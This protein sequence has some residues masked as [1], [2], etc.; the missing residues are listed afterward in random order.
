M[1][2]NKLTITINRPI[3]EV[4]DFSLDPAN[5]PKWISDIEVEETSEWPV[6]QGTI[7][8]NKRAGGAWNTYEL[9]EIVAPTTFTLTSKDTDFAVRY[10]FK[11]L[12]DQK[13]EFEYYEW[14][15]SGPLDP[16]TFDHLE[17]FK[18]IAEN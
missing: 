14:V 11:E 17:K 2:D 9:T 7:Y 6:K 3:K 1:K 13:T 10:T 4:F 12:P 8:R 5:T 16:F 18:E 15:N